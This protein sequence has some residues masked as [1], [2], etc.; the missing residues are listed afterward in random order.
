[1]SIRLYKLEYGWS[2]FATVV[3]D[4]LCHMSEQLGWSERIGFL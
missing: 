2:G 1:M 4:N 3:L